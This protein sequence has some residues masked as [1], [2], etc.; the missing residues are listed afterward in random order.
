MLHIY[1]IAD[2]GPKVF[3]CLPVVCLVWLR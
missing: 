1:D 2:D 3:I